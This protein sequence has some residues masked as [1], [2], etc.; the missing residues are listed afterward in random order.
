M[1]H[2][3]KYG[4]EKIEVKIADENFIGIIESKAVDNNKTEEQ[5]IL[6][7]LENPIGSPKLYQIVKPGETVCIVISDIT[8]SWQKMGSYLCFIVDELN[9]GG[10][11]DENIKFISATGSH[12][13][14]SEEEHRVL[15]GEK[16]ADRFKVIDHVCTDEDNLMYLGQTSYGTPVKINKIAM[17][18]DHIVITGAIV[19]H[20]LV[21]WGGGKKSL[22]PGIA[23]YE[24]IM[25]NHSM[26]LNPEMGSGSNP[27]TK[28]GKVINNPIHEDMLEAANMVKPSFMF[29]VIMDSNGKI[30][31]AVAGNY[32]E[33][34][35]KGCEIVDE[36]DRININEKAD[37]VI[38][39][40]G[41]YPKDI[42]FY[43]TIKTI[44][45]AQEA[46]KE[47]GVIVIL[48]ECSAGFGNEVIRKIIQEFG[49]VVDRE[50]ELRRNYTIEKYVGYYASEVASRTHMI[51]VSSMDPKELSMANISVVKTIDDALDLAE[52]IKGKNLKTYLMPH[53][54]NTLPKL[55]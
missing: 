31:H 3:M 35:A 33:A 13:K 53:G 54:A 50:I 42:N 48:S 27:E 39:S 46:I 55:I 41:G 22:L 7:A 45:N 10:I 51:F 38:A 4:K 9:K 24:T 16:L 6:D 52:K 49:N 2:K 1:N 21:G 25:K 40:A 20:L 18:C 34:H 36:I 11:K 44:I 5:V 8:R 15:L 14:Q 26:S 19:F 32:V 17:E 47:G 12:R 29:N 43:Q 37:M 30:A 23:G 28:S